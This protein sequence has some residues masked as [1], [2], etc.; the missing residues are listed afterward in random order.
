MAPEVPAEVETPVAFTPQDH[1]IVIGI[2][3]RCSMSHGIGFPSILHDVEPSSDQ[4]AD[5]CRWTLVTRCIDQNAGWS[6][7][8]AV[9]AS[10][11]QHAS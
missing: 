11:L 4:F 10:A 2:G 6:R 5:D 8:R 3:I 9:S 7:G 1:P